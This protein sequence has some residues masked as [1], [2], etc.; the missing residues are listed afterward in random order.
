MGQTEIYGETVFMINLIMNYAILWLTA[1]FANEV[2]HRRRLLAGSLT[3]ALYALALFL[4]DFSPLFS[5]AGKFLFSV[6][7]I[8]ISFAPL[9]LKKFFGVLGYF[10]LVSFSLIGI[11]VGVSYFVSVNR[12]VSNAYYGVLNILNRYFW[13]AILLVILVSFLVGKIG[14]T[15]IKRKVVRNFF[16]VCLTISFDNASISVEGL[17]DTGNSLKDPVSQKPVIVVEYSALENILPPGIRKAFTGGDEPKLEEILES[18]EDIE[19]SKR[20]RLIPFNSLGKVNG[21]LIAFRL[22][23][24]EILMGNEKITAENIIVGVYPRQ[25]CPEGS[26]RALLHPDILQA[27]Y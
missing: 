8:L 16:R 14:P 27:A 21:M 4:P 18:M 26:Y 7:I 22:D 11:Y 12:G 20:L 6:V 19:W 1:K 15:L 25:L 5:M 10:Y 17:I 9:R 24:V 13:Y 23:Q 3:G 2:T